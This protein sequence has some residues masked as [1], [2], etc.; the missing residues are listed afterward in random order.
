[1]R[2]REPREIQ[3]LIDDITSTIAAVQNYRGKSFRMQINPMAHTLRVL[4]FIEEGLE[5]AATHLRSLGPRRKPCF[6]FDEESE[7]SMFDQ[8]VSV[9]NYIRSR[10]LSAFQKEYL[11]YKESLPTRDLEDIYGLVHL[12]R[13]T[14]EVLSERVDE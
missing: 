12:T 9:Q 1:M 6:L 3:A 13:L 11:A 4:A 10:E 7:R 8:L 5:K 2:L 14:L